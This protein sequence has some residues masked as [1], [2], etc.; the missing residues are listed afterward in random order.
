MIYQRPTFKNIGHGHVLQIN[1]IV[2][3]LP[4]GTVTGT[5]YMNRAKNAGLY[6]DD[7]RSYYGTINNYV[8]NQI[9]ANPSQQ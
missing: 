9:T 2:A 1:R 5:T 4:P 7:T 3:I 6:I 8:K